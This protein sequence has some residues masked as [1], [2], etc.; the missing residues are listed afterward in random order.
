M[1]SKSSR[2][3]HPF[4]RGFNKHLVCTEHKISRGKVG[5]P[6]K[7]SASPKQDPPMVWLTSACPLILS[8]LVTGSHCSLK[9][10][11]TSPCGSEAS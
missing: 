11:L 3:S 8:P 7:G 10:P 9:P 5:W 4:P 6:A 1:P 2:S